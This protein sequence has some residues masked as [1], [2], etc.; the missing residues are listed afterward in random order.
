MAF[1]Y[2]FYISGIAILALLLAKGVEMKF[3]HRFSLLKLVSR[4]DKEVRV[5]YHRG[6][7]MYSESKEKGYRWAT[8]QLPYKA[9]SYVNK[10]SAFAKEK[11]EKYIGDVRNSRLIKKNDGISEFFRNISD[12]EKGK[13]EINEILEGISEKFEDKVD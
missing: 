10:S 11:L 13:G 2:A 3:K 1:A 7:H 9:K 12:L 6:V 4:W 8:K 5:V